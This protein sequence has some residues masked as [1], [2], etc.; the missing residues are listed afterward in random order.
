MRGN[1]WA[2]LGPKP[3]AVQVAPPCFG[4]G[5]YEE[6]VRSSASAISHKNW[7]SGLCV[8]LCTTRPPPPPKCAHAAAY[9]QLKGAWPPAHAITCV[10]PGMRTRA[11]TL[12]ACASRRTVKAQQKAPRTTAFRNIYLQSVEALCAGTCKGVQR[13]VPS[14]GMTRG[15]RWSGH[16]SPPGG[17][18]R[19]CSGVCA[20][21]SHGTFHWP[22][23]QGCALTLQTVPALQRRTEMQFSA[24]PA[25]PPTVFHAVLCR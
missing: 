10:R 13:T 12:V 2:H 18:G 21:D 1:H 25:G 20:S 17:T 11:P 6:V 5:V 22:Q 19:A 23:V 16:R 4:G 8:C 14:G 15:P 24:A 7:L 3:C 9:S